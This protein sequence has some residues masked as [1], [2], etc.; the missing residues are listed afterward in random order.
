VNARFRPNRPAAPP[1]ASSRPFPA[2]THITRAPER[3]HE[4]DAVRELI[5]AAQELHIPWERLL[6]DEIAVEQVLRRHAGGVD[7]E[8]P[9]ATALSLLPAS[10]LKSWRV[11]DQIQNLSCEARGASFRGAVAQLREVFRRLIGKPESGRGLY[12]GHLWLAYQRVL[13]L[14]RV[15][16]AA[17]KS[18]GTN[19]ER[20]ASIC[21]RTRCS[22]DDAA[23]ALCLEESPRPGHRLDEAVRKV[24]QE[25]FQIPREAT[26]AKSFARLRR[27]ARA[28][29]ESPA[30][31][32]RRR[33][34]GVALPQ[35]V[36]LPS[37]AV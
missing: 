2:P 31:R 4:E 11:R 36:E 18:E 6:R 29:P 9:L 21:S 13:L 28:A 1:P 19:A 8:M 20:I 14:Q 5:R 22:F 27:V 12:S 7:A 35:R 17:R 3:P 24:R 25:G 10:F 23:W 34:R 32:L 30:R 37:D 15:C 33:R 16:L 26:E